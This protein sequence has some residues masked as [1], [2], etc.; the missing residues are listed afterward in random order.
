MHSIGSAVLFQRRMPLS[1]AVIINSTATRLSAGGFDGRAA[2]IAPPAGASGALADGLGSGR[3]PRLA[4]LSRLADFFGEADR[5]LLTLGFEG[6]LFS[7][8][9][10]RRLA[11]RFGVACG[12]RLARL[13]F[14]KRLLRALGGFR[15]AAL[16]VGAGSSSALVVDALGFGGALGGLLGRN[17][18]G[19]IGGGLCFRC[20]CCCYLGL[21]HGPGLGLGLGPR[22]LIGAV[23]FGPLLFGDLTS[24]LLSVRLGLLGVELG[25]GRALFLG[26]GSRCCFRLLGQFFL[27]CLAFGFRALQ[28]SLGALLLGFALGGFRARALEH[29]DFVGLELFGFQLGGAGLTLGVLGLALGVGGGFHRFQPL[30]F[31]ALFRVLCLTGLVAG[32]GKAFG[33]GMGAGVVVVCADVFGARNHGGSHDRARQGCHRQ[34][35]RPTNRN[36]AAHVIPH[37]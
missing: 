33:D 26:G 10:T 22:Q 15:D 25:G 36:P 35:C 31:G 29:L 13:S 32:A 21:A 12:G 1:P 7:R 4:G 3:L 19:F 30:G 37:D 18:G 6:L 24:G 23:L 34:P 8:G 2:W 27:A 9:G 14:G 17:L 28:F 5:F 20:F 11:L 16:L